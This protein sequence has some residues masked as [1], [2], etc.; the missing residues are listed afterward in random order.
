MSN[1]TDE[2]VNIIEVR[3]RNLVIVFRLKSRIF[4]DFIRIILLALPSR[5]IEFSLNFKV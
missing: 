4:R 2:D 5:S 3:K 1:K